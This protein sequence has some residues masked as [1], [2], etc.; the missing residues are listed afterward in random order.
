MF[1]LRDRKNI[2]PIFKDGLDQRPFDVQG[3]ETI[4]YSNT[5]DL[6]EKLGNFLKTKKW[7]VDRD[8]SLYSKEFNVDISFREGK[9]HISKENTK[10]PVSILMKNNGKKTINGLM[11]DIE[12]DQPI[13][14]LEDYRWEGGT[15]D[16]KYRFR[17]NKIKIYP[18][19]EET[20]GSFTLLIPVQQR[21]SVHFNYY[22]YLDGLS[23]PFTGKCHIKGHR[24]RTSIFCA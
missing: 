20:V 14:I 21:I 10:I 8:K 19:L 1:G 2:V 5:S 12:F 6:K 15:N 24:E 23:E 17:S 18:K 4:S 16:I 3:L 11:L 13:I 22:L 7:V 9:I